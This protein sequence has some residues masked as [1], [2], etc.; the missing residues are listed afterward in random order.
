MTGSRSEPPHILVVEDDAPM[1]R[2]L[3][4]ALNNQGYHVRE[5]WTGR[6]AIEMIL[7]AI[8]DLILLDLGLPDMDGMAIIGRVREW[9]QV[10]ILVLS[11]RGQEGG[12][13]EALN[14]G[15]DDYVTK[16]FGIPELLARITVAL[17]HAAALKDLGSGAAAVFQ[18][19]ELEVDLAN[20][21]VTVRGEEVHLTPIEYRL[22][23]TLIRNAGKVLTHRFLLA[24][25]WGPGCS[26]QT[27]YP[28]IYVASLRK[29]L[30]DDPADPRYLLTEQGVG[31][32]LAE[33]PV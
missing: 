19:G 26:G 24:E 12:K 5:A 14:A 4:A 7:S 20:R 23:T 22:L 9:S 3:L 21:R 13:V 27:H 10:P 8:P 16:P 33:L 6:Q 11:A 1:R 30:E 2:F 32:R 15:A 29:K 17:R 31:Y 25:V 28:R 18:S